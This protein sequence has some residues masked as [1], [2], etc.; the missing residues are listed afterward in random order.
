MSGRDG[1]P[2][3]PADA[4]DVSLSGETL[5]GFLG[6]VLMALTG[7]AGTI[8]FAN[9]LGQAGL[10]AF[11]LLVALVELC[12]RPLGG[13]ARAVKKRGSEVDGAER[14]L[15][16]VQGLVS[17][18]WV[19]LVATTAFL[20]SG[21]VDAYVG[22][23]SAWWLLGATLATEALYSTF[24]PILQARGRVG[25]AVGLDAVRSYVTFPTQVVLVL[26]GFGLEGMMFGLMLA[27]VVA[28]PMAIR[29]H[30]LLPSLPSR[31]VVDRTLSYARYS[32][33]SAVVS[34]AYSRFD[35]LLLGA[36]LANPAA[37]V[38]NYGVAVRLTFPAMFVAGTAANGLFARVSNL[39]SK[40]EA[41]SQD[42]TNALAF[43]SVLAV[44]LAFGG[45]AIAEPLVRTL[46][47]GDYPGA[48]P[49]VVGMGV[50]RLVE[51]QTSILSGVLD[52]LD[53]PEVVF[54]VSTLGLAVNVALGVGL[55]YSIG[56]IG[57]LLA[58]IAAQTLMYGVFA[59]LVRRALPDVSLVPR[60]LVEQMVAGGVMFGAVAALDGAIAVDSWLDLSALLLAGAAVY[61]LVLLA[62]STRTR[63]MVVT[64]L[65]HAGLDG[66]LPGG[67][68]NRG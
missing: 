27:S 9:L 60:P 44:P 46:F 30:R 45:A 58:T 31:A 65:G 68:R 8:I 66:F 20:L 21:R 23:E 53:R 11:Y 17:V 16:G 5:K 51:T 56:P 52:G 3:A 32:V 39:H 2:D 12:E 24:V 13:L 37:A 48:A 57:V 26:L 28:V 55:V 67:A 36:I 6:Q 59:V 41:L 18:G 43:A 50:Y 10:G 34:K 7:F 15:M 47:S 25:L 40:E 35:T 54:R 63:G 42:V 19:A 22:S 62:I 64:V 61:G 1:D 38:A 33:P 29:S 14:E 4:S 49:F